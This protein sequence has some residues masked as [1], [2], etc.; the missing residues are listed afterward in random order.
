MSKETLSVENMELDVVIDSKEEAIRYVGNILVD[1]GYVAP[2]YI[3]KMLKRE[4]LTST[5]MGNY[6]AIPHGTEDSKEEVLNTGISLITVP[7][8]VDFGEGNI[9]KVIFGIAGKND[10]HLEVLSQIAIVCSEEENVEAILKADSKEAILELFS[11]V[12]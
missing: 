4:E 12:N 8:G 3:E 11:E 7:D 2:D 9:A 5:Y 10:E 6:I 1:R